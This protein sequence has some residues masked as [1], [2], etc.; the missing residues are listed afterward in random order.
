MKTERHGFSVTAKTPPSIEF[1][2]YV[3]AVYVR[4]K[5]TRV[6]KTIPQPAEHCHIAIDLDS[7]G[8]VVGIEGIGFTSFTIQ[9]LLKM[10]KV[11]IPEGMDF[12]KA[13]YEMNP[14]TC[15]A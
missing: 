3:G 10:S 7:E 1:D 14:E 15:A 2:P 4:F 11:T 12:S 8:E 5:K 13:R 6:V 9:K